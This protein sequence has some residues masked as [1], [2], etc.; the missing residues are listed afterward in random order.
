MTS[1]KHNNQRVHS[2]RL[3]RSD[4]DVGYRQP[5]REHQFKPGQSRNPKGRRKGA[6]NEAT[7]L[8]EMLYRKIPIREGGRT[9]KI[10]ILEA[11]LL[12]FTEDSLKGNTKSATFLL[13]RHTLMTSGQPAPEEALPDE[14]KEI[15]E[16]YAQ[17]FITRHSSKK[18]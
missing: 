3:K 10:T 15:L 13:N 12:R 17:R 8:Q 2:V 18:R 11:I 16:A 1:K 7:M 6:K 14:D 9:R 5:P 4:I